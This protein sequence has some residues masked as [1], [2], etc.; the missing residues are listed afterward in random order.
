MG[1]FFL[2]QYP[3]MDFAGAPR[4]FAADLRAAMADAPRPVRVAVY[5]EM[6]AGF[7]YYMNEPGSMKEIL[8]SADL[9]DILNAG[10]GTCVVVAHRRFLSRVRDLGMPAELIQNPDVKEPAMPWD[11]E[12]DT[13]ECLRAF[14][15]DGVGTKQG[16]GE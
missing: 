10:P 15:M 16:A 8:T 13:L 5:K 9:R 4:G 2:V 11:A 1:G 6:P 7:V 3:A 12:E 14:I